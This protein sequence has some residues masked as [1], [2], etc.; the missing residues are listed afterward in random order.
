MGDLVRDVKYLRFYHTSED[1]TKDKDILKNQTFTKYANRVGSL[2]LLPMGFQLW[3]I[4]LVNNFEKL[5]LY[6]KVRVLKFV[7]FWAALGLGIKEKLN[8]EYQW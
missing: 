7:T 1:M 6:R 8:L 5:A 3:Q 2:F 4:S